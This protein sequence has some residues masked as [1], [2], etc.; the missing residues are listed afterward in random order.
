MATGIV[1]TIQKND[2]ITSIADGVNSCYGVTVDAIEQAN[3]NVN[4]NNLQVGTTL[5]IPAQPAPQ[6]S[7]SGFS[8]QPLVKAQ[9]IGYW[10]WTWAATNTAPQGATLGFAMSGYAD[11][12]DALQSSQPIYDALFG[13]KIITL[14][15]GTD[16]G[17]FT[18]STLDSIN[19]AITSG[20]FDAYQGI[21]YDVES[22]DSGL[23]DAFA[24]SFQLAYARGFLVVVT[25]SHSAPYGVPDAQAL[26]TSF[27]SSPYIDFLSP[28]LYTSG[29]EP[30]NDFTTASG[31]EWTDYATAKAAVIPSIIQSSYYD[32]AQ[33][34]F[35][36]YGVT[37]KGYI[38]W[39]QT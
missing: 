38:C 35:A 25:V 20:Q 17:Y 16:P 4:P 14:G 11:P 32:N 21:A 2:T 12:T 13:T 3:P 7:S 6:P 19:Q 30:T 23:E 27:F 1:Y 33:T 28:Q 10:D 31:V 18:S 39:D 26:M 37:T 34:T 9:N 5:A 29:Q 24:T 36:T 22:G 15:G 8:S